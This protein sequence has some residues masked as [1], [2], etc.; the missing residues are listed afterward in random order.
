MSLLIGTISKASNVANGPLV[1]YHLFD[2]YISFLC[3]N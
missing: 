1:S 2:Y 3:V